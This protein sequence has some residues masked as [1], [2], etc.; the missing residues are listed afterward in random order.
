MK[1]EAGKDVARAP[2][3]GDLT[4]NLDMAVKKAAAAN[5]GFIFVLLQVAQLSSLRKRR[6][7]E[8]VASLLRELYHAVRAVVHP[9]QFVAVYKD[10]VGVVFDG[11]DAGRVDEVVRRL[12]VLGDRV[13][14]DGHYNDLSMSISDLLYQLLTISPAEVSTAAGWA[15]Y[16][17]DG[18]SGADILKRASYHLAE[19]AR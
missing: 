13:L 1:T 7:P 2:I 5:R 9:S 19:R 11:V 16:P 10:G 4:G 15:I 17:R 3:A 18:Q 12:I 8:V 14:K 6:S